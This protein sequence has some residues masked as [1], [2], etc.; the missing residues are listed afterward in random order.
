MK[1]VS[2][3]NDEL[4][5]FNLPVL[6]K[7][8]NL[9]DGNDKISDDNMKFCKNVWYKNG[10]LKTRPALFGDTQNIIGKNLLTDG[11]NFEWR[12]TETEVF[13]NGQN[14]RIAF[15]QTFY[16][17]SACFVYAFLI[18]Q[19]G[20]ATNIGNMQFIR[21][22]ANT[23]YIPE[24]ITFYVAEK[25]N[26]GGI[27]AL[28]TLVNMVD[29]ESR[30]Y[31]IYEIS[32]DFKA[33]NKSYNFYVPTVYINGRGNCYHLAKQAGVAVDATPKE[34][35]TLNMLDGRFYAYYS[36]DGYST[37]FR[38][39]FSKLSG[40]T[41]FCRIYTNADSYIEWFIDSDTSTK[42]VN[43]IDTDITI[44]LDRER[45]I[46]SFY[47]GGYE[48]AIPQ[49]TDYKENNI[50]FFA[51]KD[52]PEALS[53][54]VSCRHT[55]PSNSKNLFSGGICGSEIYYSSFSNPLY[56]PMV[57]GNQIG[58]PANDVTGLTPLGNKVLAFKEDE[59]HSVELENSKPLNSTNLLLDNSNIFHKVSEFKIK[60]VS[61]NVGTENKSTISKIGKHLLWQNKSGD[62]CALSNNNITTI[63]GE[64]K[65]YLEELLSDSSTSPHATSF[66]NYYLLCKGSKAIIANLQSKTDYSWFIWEFPNECEICGAF[67]YKGKPFLL[68]TNRAKNLCYL[69]LLK[70]E[71]DIILNYENENPTHKEF[72]IETIVETKKYPLSPMGKRVKISKIYL[73]L[74][75]L[76]NTEINVIGND[77]VSRFSL[78]ETDICKKMP[79]TIK[80][81]PNFKS[82]GGI[83]L[84]LKSHKPFKLGKAQI[85]FNQMN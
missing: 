13:Y 73:D 40:E 74:A 61:D 23:F 15:A 8:V 76:G 24:N 32:E 77:G 52:I 54:I 48:F 25:V 75:A 17:N 68:C 16:S 21:T 1:Y 4:K 83:S 30:L 33:W 5:C 59:I 18:D 47:S 58:S 67:S 64:I 50:R 29:F 46:V 55:C 7:G 36:S 39:P 11:V 41:V 79:K 57:W 44:K 27:F 85:Y 38:L 66:G 6:D 72:N 3:K 31:H 80:L 20:N 19:E 35:E 34:L 69:S 2:P 84:L 78:C 62:I 63:S 71:K 56:F 28:I 43:Y 49:M 81:S 45:G 42:T 9:Y 60:V 22:D 10:I 26:G 37:S 53:Q 70:G 14:H 82:T 12:L 51:K 65:P